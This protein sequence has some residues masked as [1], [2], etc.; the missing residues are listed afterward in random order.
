MAIAPSVRAEDPRYAIYGLPGQQFVIDQKAHLTWERAFSS[1]STIDE[2]RK[3]CTDA[4]WRLPTYKELL[5]LVDYG[6]MSFPFAL[7]DLDTFP[8][9]PA[10]A[11]WSSSRDVT[12]SPFAFH[13]VDFANGMEG[14]TDQLERAASRCVYTAPPMN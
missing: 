5:T 13:L 7:V 3:R 14:G 2:A 1:P 6:S 4:G 10:V 9:T 8:G 11:F 12:G